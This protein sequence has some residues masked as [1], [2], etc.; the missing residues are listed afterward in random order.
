MTR[1]RPTLLGFLA[2]GLLLSGN[3]PFL[4]AASAQEPIRFARMPDISPDGKLVT[5]SYLGDVWVVETIGGVARPVTMHERHDTTPVFSPDGR[6]IAFSSNRHGSYDVF[7]VPVQGGRPTRLTYDSADE[8][9]TGW[10]PDG[11][12]VLFSAQRGA[13]FPRRFEMYCVP[14]TGGR[15]KQ[16]SSFEGREGVVAPAGDLMAYVRGPGTWYRKG[17][18]GSSN[19]DIWVCKL[20]GSANQQFTSFPGQ[21]TSPMW[22]PDGKALYYVSEFHGTPANIVRQELGDLRNGLTVKSAPQQLTCHKDDGVRQARVSGNGEWIVYECG[23]DL[24]VLSTRTGQTRKLAIEVHADD[25]TNPER[26]VTYTKDATEFAPSYDERFI[27]F[28]VH[29]EIFLIPRQGGKAKQLTHSPA[30]DHGVAWSPDSRKLVFLSD[31]NGHEDIYLLEPDDPETMYLT[32]ANK[33]KVKALTNTPEAESAVS[34]SPNGKHISFLRAGKLLIMNPDGTDQKTIVDQQTVIDYEWS[35][36]SQWLAYARMDGS[37][38]SELYIV[39]ATGPTATHPARNVTRYATYN[40]GVTW[41]QTGNKLAFISQRGRNPQSLYVLSLQKPA[42]ADAANS[43]EIDWDDIHLRVQHVIPATVVEAAI[44]NDGKRVAFAGAS[45]GALDLWVANVDVSSIQR[46]TTGNTRPT[47]IRWSRLAPSLLYFRDGQGRIR[48]TSAGGLNPLP[49]GPLGPKAGPSDAAATIPFQAKVVI[50]REEEFA[51]VFKQSWRALNENFYDPA[52]HGADWK[53][54]RD[55]YRPL[56]KHVSMREDLYALISLMLGE[57]NASHLGINGPP[58]VP[59]QVT[60]ELGLVFD[61]NYPGPGLKVSEILKRGPADKRGLKIKPGDVIVSIDRAPV[62]NDTDVARLLNDKV[63]ETVSVQVSATPADPKSWHRV[64]LQGIRREQATG[65][66]YERWVAQNARRVAQVSKGKLG[67]I[68]IPSMDDAGLDR[69]VRALYS[70]N[71]D[72]DGIVLDVRYNGGGFTHDQVLNYLGGKAHTFFY[73][74]NGGQGMVLRSSD[75]KWTKP[76]VLLINNRSYSDAEIFPNAFRTLGLGKLVGQPTGGFVIGT[77]GL[78]L[79]DGSIFRVPRV[80]VVTA[81]GVSMEK[82]GV[83][84][85]FAVEVHPDQLARGVDAQLDKAVEVLTRDV[86][87]WKKAGGERTVTLPSTQP[88]GA[89]GAPG[90][91]G[92]PKD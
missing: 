61:R 31:R 91:T 72:K 4:A 9:V 77:G 10:T 75:R 3:H 82:E 43:K 42:A 86:V 76:L 2:V 29:G 36:D 1:V 23:L 35:P 88:T 69:F 87:A 7:V 15:V 92:P 85:D 81:K 73:Q 21:D 30:N 65:L 27:A 22:A 25:K 64:E 28:V 11:K 89:V 58:S 51:E 68:H 74:R 90:R 49:S 32:K 18:R 84:P 45:G 34:F 44:S 79:I 60:A 48:L 6:K 8:F 50:S 63:G 53:T 5:F 66:M 83:A 16:I 71:F 14:A 13:D 78:K 52:F 33:F 37:F 38:A 19:D 17:Y 20:D 56:I 59:E 41:S 80:G 39:P 46:L 26:T 47:E 67:Y 70:D 40:A 24:Y 54:I 62:T 57:L 55:K 12:N